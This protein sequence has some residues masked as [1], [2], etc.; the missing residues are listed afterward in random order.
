MA[1]RRRAKRAAP[2]AASAASSSSRSPG[3]LPYIARYRG[4]ALAAL[5]ALTVAP[6]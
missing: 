4:R 1:R 3:L 5:L 2:A 6:R